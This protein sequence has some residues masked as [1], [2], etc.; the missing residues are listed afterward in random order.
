M[1]LELDGHV[2]IFDEAHNMED[3]SR[4]SSSFS[5]KQDDLNNAKQ[6]CEKLIRFGSEPFAHGMLVS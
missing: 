3:A 5:I 6:D 4:E 2:L 1:N